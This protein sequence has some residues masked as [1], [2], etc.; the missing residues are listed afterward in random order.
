MPTTD[1]RG[2]TV[3]SSR[4]VAII[5]M[6]EIPAIEV[7]RDKLKN[8]NLALLKQIQDFNSKLLNIDKVSICAKCTNNSKS[9]Y[10]IILSTKEKELKLREREVHLLQT[11]LKTTENDFSVTKTESVALINKLKEFEK[12][13][14]SMEAKNFDLMKSLLADKEME[15]DEEKASLGKLYNQKLSDF[16]KKALQ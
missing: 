10:A 5:Y 7:E 14:S 11:K 12:K 3:L 2:N 8:E 16:S 1:K 9:D 4:D 6:L 13:I 15:K